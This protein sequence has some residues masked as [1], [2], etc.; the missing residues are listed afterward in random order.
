MQ[1]FFKM[2]DTGDGKLIELKDIAKGNKSLIVS[3][4]YLQLINL[5]VLITLIN[6]V[7][8]LIHF[9]TCASCLGVIT[10]PQYRVLDPVRL[11][12]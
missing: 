12:N 8:P 7:L 11:L 10:F 1:V 6:R 3:V 2:T 4:I 5:C 9:V